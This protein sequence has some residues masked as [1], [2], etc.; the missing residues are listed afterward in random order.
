M[1]W[2][3][4]N[5]IKRQEW[6]GMENWHLKLCQ[7][8]PRSGDRCLVA[9]RPASRW[10][11]TCR[12]RGLD[13]APFP[14]G[15]DLAPWALLRL[16][17]ICRRFQPDIAI[18]KGFRS[19]RFMR[20]AWPSAA[21]AVKLPFAD[22]LN[23]APIDRWTFARCV[24]R[25]LT[26][27][28]LARAAFLRYPWVLP[29]KVV[30]VH[31]GVAVPD[32]DELARDRSRLRRHFPIPP[33]RLIIA[34]A[35]RLTPEKGFADILAALSLMGPRPCVH[36]LILG[37]G[38]EAGPLRALA[39]HLNLTDRVTFAGWRDD[40]RS[41]IRGA[42]LFLHASQ[43][44]GLP[45]VVLEAMADAL[46]VIA[47]DAGGTREIFSRPGL[48]SL[49]PIR[50]P[51]AIAAALAPLLADATLRAARGAA[52]R[53]HVREHF[54]L[55]VMARRIRDSLRATRTLKG[56]LPLHTQGRPGPPIRILR[57]TDT[58]PIAADPLL[59]APASD[60]EPV[61]RSTKAL[62]HRLRQGEETYYI[63]RFVD[64][65]FHLR[66]LRLRAPAAMA[67][68]MIARRLELKGA[69]VVPHLMAVWPG[70]TR[71]PSVLLTGAPPSLSTLADWA[72]ARAG[73]ADTRRRL[74]RDLAT[75]LARLHTVGIACHDL[76]TTNML[77]HAQPEG[78]LDFVLL[79][80]D[81]CRVRAC[82]VGPLGT[83]RN[84]H[85][86]FRSFHALA[87]PRE[88]LRFL[89]VYRCFRRLSR[90]QTRALARRVE[91]RMTRRGPGFQALCQAPG[92]DP[93]EQRGNGLP[94]AA[95]GRGGPGP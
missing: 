17:L 13:F 41:L 91:A 64:D 77:I 33:E 46:P 32:D 4:L 6:G 79:D 12:A 45:N 82:P 66:R 83:A 3:F 48:G 24:D 44:E 61:T 39:A 58:P 69:A 20:L 85:Q 65:T 29:G 38:P 72:R 50:A 19:A 23:D 75:W 90:R 84:L 53:A 86:V 56:A 68:L 7:E 76:K 73:E 25:I 21:I 27:N 95:Q 67:N 81:N 78:G 55:P 87:T 70:P 34:C 37:E 11:A 63:K 52:A 8:L 30:T 49:V 74:I 1:N 40:A 9:A 93:H 89:G 16:R 15:F 57:N 5:P 10:P 31:N 26:D 2:L 42:D 88:A 28:H 54:S 94:P 62:V 51:A 60:W 18:A 92:R 35:G 80:L 43:S 71:S 59:G 14:F 47:T 36:L 22:D